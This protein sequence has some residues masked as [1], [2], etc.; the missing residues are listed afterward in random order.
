MRFRAAFLAVITAIAAMLLASPVG[1]AQTESHAVAEPVAAV[2][3]AIDDIS[4]RAYSDCASGY[5]CFWT[6]S[7]GAGNRCAWS[8]NS[9]NASACSW[10]STTNVRSIYNRT[11][12]AIIYYTGT[13][14][15][16]RIGCTRPGVS[17]NLAGNYK[18]RS[19]Q[20]VASC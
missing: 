12:S 19:L 5:A 4:T 15:T 2:Q 20:F 16:N 6:G 11:S 7:G 14:Y 1:L 13:N 8:S 10:S 17:G 3:P 9:S 18:V